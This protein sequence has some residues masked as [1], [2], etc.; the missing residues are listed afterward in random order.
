MGKYGV[1]KAARKGYINSKWRVAG[2]ELNLTCTFYEAAPV[3]SIF[4]V[5]SFILLLPPSYAIVCVC[6]S[7]SLCLCVSVSLCLCVSVSLCLSLALY[8]IIFL[9]TRTRANPSRCIAFLSDCY[10]ILQ[11]HIQCMSR[12]KG[13]HLYHDDSNLIAAEAGENITLFNLLFRV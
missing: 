7:V 2:V 11:Y 12:A 10:N 5:P 9:L 13:V 3:P 8:T 4:T 1:N 6:V